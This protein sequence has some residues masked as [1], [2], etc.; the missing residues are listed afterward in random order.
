MRLNLT[1]P[2]YILFLFSC[3]RTNQPTPQPDPNPGPTP[4]TTHHVPL[5]L[6]L[7]DSYIIYDLDMREIIFNTGKMNYDGS[8]RL[9]DIYVTVA[10]STADHIPLRPDTTDFTLIYNGSDSLPSSYT[11]VEAYTF[12]GR[13][14]LTYDNLGR[15]SQDSGTSIQSSWLYK[16]QYNEGKIIRNSDYG[17]DSIIIVNNNV[18][19]LK[20]SLVIY[21]FT[22][23]TYPNPFY[24]PNLANH[25]TPLMV[26][27]GPDIF[28][29]NLFNSS[30]A[31]YTNSDPYQ[32][33]N[34]SWTT[35]A[36]GQ[37]ISG[38]G[39]DANSGVVLQYYWFTYRK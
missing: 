6:P 1:L 30:T 15:M 39:K 35:N 2:I 22:Y 18:Q 34:Y 28:S 29:K 38:I 12:T 13:G 24:Q 14:F 27:E 26:F 37:V 23:S 7:L 33:I 19:L 16:Y 9:H 25:I 4:D 20:Q 3:T 5:S 36:N 17:T 21:S 11:K 8:G 32:V 31:Q 10:D